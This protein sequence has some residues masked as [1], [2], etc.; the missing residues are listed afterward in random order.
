MEFMFVTLDVPQLETFSLNVAKLRNR[1]PMSVIDE[2][3]QPEIGPYV[4]RAVARSLFH[5]WTAVSREAFVTKDGGGGGADAD[6]DE[7]VASMSVNIRRPKAIALCKH[8]PRNE[9]CTSNAHGRRSATLRP[10]PRPSTRRH[11]G[12]TRTLWP[13]RSRTQRRAVQG[14]PSRRCDG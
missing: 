1:L 2:T 13:T 7:L 8:R 9:F 3:P 4:L 10:E 5:I 6:T 14:G 11:T 12:G